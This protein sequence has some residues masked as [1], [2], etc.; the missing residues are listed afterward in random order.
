MWNNS[1][2]FVLLIKR[3]LYSFI[4]AEGL[5]IFFCVYHFSKLHLTFFEFLKAI[6]FGLRFDS[7]ALGILLSPFVLMHLFPFN[8]FEKYLE[9]PR[10]IYWLLAINLFVLISLIDT[11]YFNYTGKRSTYDFIKLNF[12]NTDL[13]IQGPK[14]VLEYWYWWLAFFILAFLLSKYYPKRTFEK[15]GMAKVSTLRNIIYS[16][17]ILSLLVISF[18]GGV[19]GR[20]LKSIA[21]AEYIPPQKTS[22]VLNTPFTLITTFGENGIEVPNYYPENELENIYPMV[23]PSNSKKINKKNVVIIVVESLGR[24]WMGFFGSNKSCTP[25]LDSL[26][27]K[28]FV[29]LNGFAN[30]QR[31]IEG[32][33]A[34]FS[35]LPHMTENAFITSSYGGSTELNSLANL[36]GPFG[37]QSGFFHGGNNG[38]MAFDWYFKS[39][40]FEKY[41]GRKQYPNPNVFDG[42][43]GVP[44]F[45]FLEF[46]EKEISKFKQPFVAGIFTLSS[47]HPYKIPQPFKD[48]KGLNEYQKS[49]VYAD[50]SLRHFFNQSRKEKWFDETIFV[51]TSD[52]TSYS[53]KEYFQTSIGAFA[54]PIIYYSPKE[55]VPS[56]FSAPTG[57]IDIM[58]SV[59]GLLN[60]PKKYVSAGKNIFGEKNNSSIMM[61]NNIYQT[62]DN[63]SVIMFDGKNCIGN[64]DVFDSTFS[65][66]RLGEVDTNELKKL[67]AFIQNFY[68]RLSKNKLK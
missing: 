34:I 47:H 30:A 9:I 22:S 53:E 50:N 14:Y 28:S 46:A 8:L 26:C 59:L 25:F 62:V 16:L 15:G 40:G 42:F 43:W 63:K 6:F 32:I 67:K 64:Y 4:I 35:G 49:L 2:G 24:E 17:V 57:Q 36:L 66:N 41:F 44:D 23:H 21:A 58:P 31:S 60:Y 65:T 7:M 11:A 20:P 38:T 5:R 61:I 10:K 51:I 39:I 52:H 12:N 29:C 37:Y 48:L 18:R 13:L 55:L 33:P 27:G 45:E 54:I 56:K 3:I 1:S 68:L 19:Q